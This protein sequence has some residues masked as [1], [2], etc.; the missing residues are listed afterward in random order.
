MPFIAQW[1]PYL[2]ADAEAIKYTD[3]QEIFPYTTDTLGTLFY[4]T[5]FGNLGTTADP[6]M[7]STIAGMTFLMV[8]A[9]VLVYLV[10]CKRRVTVYEL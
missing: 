1:R 9:G 6:A 7:G 10:K 8:L 5:Y 4:R 3:T 2:P